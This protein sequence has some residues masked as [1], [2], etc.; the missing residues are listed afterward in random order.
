MPKVMVEVEM[1]QRQV[2]LM[3]ATLKVAEAHFTTTG[4]FKV[5]SELHKMHKELN[6]QMFN[7]TPGDVDE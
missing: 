5:A 3:F 6:K 1:S 4:N 7:Y 2:D